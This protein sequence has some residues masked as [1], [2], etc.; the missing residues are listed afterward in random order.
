VSDHLARAVACDG[1]VR[2]LAVVTTGLAEEAR[3]RHGTLPTATAALG[4]GLTAALL[5]SA[6]LKDDERIS[7]E[8]SGNGPLGTMLVDATPAGEVRGFVSRPLTHLPARDGKLDVGGAVGRGVLCVL[9]TLAGTAAPYRGIVPL[10]S[11]EIGTDVASYLVGSEQLPA[12]MGVGVFVEPDGRVSAA[13]GY[14]LQAMPGAEPGTIERL[15]ANVATAGR[16]T[17]LVRRGLDAAAMLDQLVAGLPLRVVDTRAVR[18]RCRCS[19]ER[20][21][22]ALIAMGRAELLDVLGTERRAEVACEF[23]GE[24]WIVEEAEL[25]T[26]PALS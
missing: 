25:R 19:R 1:A 4:R 22:A 8:F 17:D 18:F 11:G 2:A 16:P 9:R 13:G 21:T 20:A 26:Y 3:V 10:V 14:L 12:A 15:E 6:L 7:L 23:C 5:V 24:R